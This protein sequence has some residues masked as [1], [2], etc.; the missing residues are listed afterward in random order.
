MG[1]QHSECFNYGVHL[2][3]LDVAAACVQAIDTIC[4]LGDSQRQHHTAADHAAL[5]ACRC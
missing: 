5:H 1:G 4:G 3:L 2:M